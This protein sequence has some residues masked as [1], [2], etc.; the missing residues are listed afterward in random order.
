MGKWI[1]S[2]VSEVLSQTT[3]DVFVLPLVHIPRTDFT[4][5]FFHKFFKAPS[6]LVSPEQCRQLNQH[7]L[8]VKLQKLI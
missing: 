2:L 5:K 4:T 8:R 7:D 6:T 3:M 1:R